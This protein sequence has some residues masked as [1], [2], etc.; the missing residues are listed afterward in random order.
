MATYAYLRV[1]TDAQDVENQKHGI[2]EYCNNKNLGKTIFI[3]DTASGKKNW[4]DRKLG[5]LLIDTAVAGD[6][7]I[8]AEFSRIGRSTLQVLEVLKLA[9]EAEI[10]VHIAKDKIIMDD[11]IQATIYATVLG[12]ASEIER[13]FIAMRTKESI[14]RCK[15]DIEEKGY[16]INAK[17]KKV[18][19]LG[20]PKG[21][22]QQTK[23]DAK[24]EEI[25]KYLKLGVAKRSIS[26]ILECSP[27]TLYAWIKKKGGE[28]KLK[29]SEVKK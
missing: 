10:Q 23:L 18:T 22:A 6:T 2:L 21:Q 16:F 28:D 12:L 5:E 27:S 14:A 26:K 9:V 13:N 24:S 11:S 19:S 7:I 17:G 20:R 25:I 3:E 8:F 29:E 4:R 15:K 1:S